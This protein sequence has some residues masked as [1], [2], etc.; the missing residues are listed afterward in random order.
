MAGTATAA[1]N[2]RNRVQQWDEL[3]DVMPV[4]AGQR[5]GEWCAVTVDYHMVLAAGT[6]AVDR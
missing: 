5:D 4:A 2:A 6:A 1:A 3:G